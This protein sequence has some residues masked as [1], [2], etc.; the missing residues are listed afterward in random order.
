MPIEFEKHPISKNFYDISPL[1]SLT[2]LDRL[3]QSFRW[4]IIRLPEL[5]AAAKILD[6]HFFL[7][8]IEQ[9]S[10]EMSIR[11]SPV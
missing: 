11:A 6:N 4:M 7:T 5:R 1:R 9:L 8:K 2:S 10:G 3:N